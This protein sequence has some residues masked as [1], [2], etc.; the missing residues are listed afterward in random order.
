ML[1]PVLFRAG[2]WLATEVREAVQRR[3]EAR[4]LDLGCGTGVV[5]VLAAGVGA[6]VVASDLTPDACAAARANG[7]LDVRRGDLFEALPGER[8]DL[9]AF[10]PPY[11][12]G[13]PDRHPFG[14]A[15]YGGEDLGVLRR[16]GQLVPE[17]LLPGGE[18]WTVVSDRAP[19]AVAALGPG[20]RRIR[21]TQTK[22]ESLGIWALG[23]RSG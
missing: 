16:F 21:T 6:A 10:N 9:V 3:P 13:R 22:G 12:A 20:W 7:L 11:L 23:P 15:L 17:H 5:G 2:A 8:F 14:R 19:G 1:D 18:A 4:V